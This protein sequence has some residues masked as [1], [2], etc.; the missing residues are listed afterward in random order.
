[1]NP[2]QAIGNKTSPDFCI[3]ILPLPEQDK[4]QRPGRGFFM[5]QFPILCFFMLTLGI[6]P[7]SKRTML[8]RIFRLSLPVVLH[9]R[10]SH[11]ALFRHHHLRTQH[12]QPGKF[13]LTDFVVSG[14]SLII[15]FISPGYYQEAQNSLHLQ[16]PNP[17]FYESQ[18][19]IRH[20]V[21]GTDADFP[22]GRTP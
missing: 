11:R 16:K 14:Y 13:L 6:K 15:I 8:L 12:K 20:R 18:T 3:I 19:T 9:C 4:K 2:F 7:L 17:I 1:M 10:S 5:P 22:A 21:S